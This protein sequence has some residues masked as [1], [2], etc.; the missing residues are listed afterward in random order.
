MALSVS[1]LFTPV[2]EDQAFETFLS[3]LET[4]SIPAR[5]WRIGG[6]F[7][8]ILKV[9]ARSYAGGIPRRG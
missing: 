7:R 5:S 1:Q 3:T 8:N 6:A 4:L 2:T 9:V